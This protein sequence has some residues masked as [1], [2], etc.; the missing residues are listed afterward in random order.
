MY[1]DF[2]TTVLFLGGNIQ[3]ARREV[4]VDLQLRRIHSRREIY[5]MLVKESDQTQDRTRNAAN[6]RIA[7]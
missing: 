1:L 4:R 5:D 6:K 7:R 2:A 3:K